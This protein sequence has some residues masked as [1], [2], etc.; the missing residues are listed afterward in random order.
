MNLVDSFKQNKDLSRMGEEVED[1]ISGFRG[2][3]VT[4]HLY[5]NGCAR[6]TVQPKVGDD[7]TLPDAV[8]FDLPQLRCIKNNSYNIDNT[9]GGPEKYMDEGR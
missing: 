3:I 5:I 1:L 6:A 8:T 4:L 2:I 9:T 7:N